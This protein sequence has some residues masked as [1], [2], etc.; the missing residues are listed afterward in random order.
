M[1]VMVQMVRHM[2]PPL[3]LQI[4]ATTMTRKKAVTF[5]AVQQVLWQAAVHY[6]PSVQE[7]L[8]HFLKRYNPYVQIYK[9]TVN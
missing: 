1:D 7:N 6:R 5:V 4:T 3:W 2:L 9:L 8:R